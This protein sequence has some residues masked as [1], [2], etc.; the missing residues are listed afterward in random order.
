MKKKKHRRC[1]WLV[2]GEDK[3][4]FWQKFFKKKKKRV[5]GYFNLNIM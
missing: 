3:K 2:E 5:K 4:N 1:L